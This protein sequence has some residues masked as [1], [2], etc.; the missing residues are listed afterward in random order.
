MQMNL[1][2][3][4]IATGIGEADLAR[5]A[6]REGFLALGFGDLESLI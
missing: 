4:S 2:I 6:M 1:K 3:R 5:A